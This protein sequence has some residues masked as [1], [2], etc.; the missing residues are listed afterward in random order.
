[1]IK[2]KIHKKKIAVVIPCYRVKNHI[3]LV[4]EK[5][6]KEVGMIF[7]IDDHCPEN[8]GNFVKAVNKDKR[9]QIIFHD[10]NQGVGGAVISGYKA[11][12]MAGATIIIKI[13]GDGQMN[14]DL[15]PSFIKPILDG[16][17]DY[18]KGNRFFN[19][20]NLLEMPFSRLFGNS[21]I[22][23]INKAVSG[24]WDI[25]D[26]SNGYTAI[27][28]S[29]LRQLPL[30]KVD[31]RYFFESDMLFWL[32]SIRA[33]VQDI[34]MKSIY[35]NESSNLKIKRILFE[36]PIKYFKR[37]FQ[38]IFYT[39]FLRDFNAGT[40]QIIS[41]VIFTFSGFIFGLHEWS[42]SIESGIPATSGTVMLAALPFL[43]GVQLMISAINYDIKSVPRNPIHDDMN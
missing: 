11:A 34:P 37:F 26:P 21:M 16:K 27:H 25:M 10:E 28:A 12:V 40:V 43:V 33:V 22:S 24:Y 36:F 17:A 31:P 14:P 19:I 23:L 20:K 18:T 8:S 4:L 32:S 39:Y 42:K 1:M 38:R 35:E 9:V 15:I 29:V 7:I 3:R 30:E 13:D 5:I 41:G 2:E 6:P